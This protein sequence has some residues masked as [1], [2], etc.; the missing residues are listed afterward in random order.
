MLPSP[1]ILLFVTLFDIGLTSFVLI[2]D[3]SDRAQSPEG[4]HSFFMFN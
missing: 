3:M 1:G 4:T 2:L